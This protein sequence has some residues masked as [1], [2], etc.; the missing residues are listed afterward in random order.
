M[1][2]ALRHR[3]LSLSMQLL[4]LLDFLLEQA[5]LV[6]ERG[7]LLFFL[8]VLLLEGLVLGLQLVHFACGFVGFNAEGIHSLEDDVLAHAW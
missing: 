2:C 8:E 3:C 7:N 4:E 6:L 1:L 5:V